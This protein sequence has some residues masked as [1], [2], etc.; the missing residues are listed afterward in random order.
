MLRI[1]DKQKAVVVFLENESHVHQ[2]IESSVFISESFVQVSP[3]S[4]PSMRITVSGVLPF[5]P[6]ELLENELRRF[7]KFA[8]GLKTI[9]LGCKD[10]K[11]KHV[12]PLRR[13]VFMFL[14]SPAQTLE[15]SFRVTYS[16]GVYMVYASSRHMRCFECGDVGHKRFACPHK[17]QMDVAADA[18]PGPAAADV[19]SPTRLAAGGGLKVDCGGVAA[20]TRGTS[21]HC[22]DVTEEK[23]QLVAAEN[24]ISVKS[25]AVEAQS[26]PAGQ[27]EEIASTSV[28]CSGQA[29]ANSKISGEEDMSES[30]SVGDFSS[31]NPELYS[32]EEINEFLDETFKKSVKMSDCFD[33]TDKFI[34]SVGILKRLVGFDLLDEKK[35]FRLKKH[36]TTHN[37]AAKSRPGSERNQEV[38]MH[39]HKVVSSLHCSLLVSA[40]LFLFSDLFMPSLKIGSLNINGGRDRHKRALISEVS[41]QKRADVLFLQE[42][43]TTAADK[44][45]WGLWWEG[46]H[47]LS[48][49]TNFSAGVA[50]LF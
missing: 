23:Q 15:V 33:D 42:T 22:K 46:P 7:G 34:K 39:D 49:G 8:S 31:R 12:K 30:V 25:A 2:L 21:S 47:F 27:V 6:N 3:L 17:R 19:T 16:E 36:I 10:P 48:H 1:T 5:I 28:V 32:L 18:A 24:V 14:D 9:S 37:K 40:C 50:I 44:T 4:V 38:I 41:T 35:R 20:E 45:D 11:L 26:H 43:L 29:V 13:Q